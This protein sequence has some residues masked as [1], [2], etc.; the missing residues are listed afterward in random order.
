MSFQTNS[1][2]AL[3]AKLHLCLLFLLRSVGCTGKLLIELVD[4]SRRIDKLQFAC[5]KG[6]ANAANIYFEFRLGRPGRKFVPATTGYLRFHVFRMY[7]LFH[8]ILH[9]TILT[10]Y[11]KWDKIKGATSPA[12]VYFD[13][14]WTQSRSNSRPLSRWEVFSDAG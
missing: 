7:V 13:L 14:I 6:M 9:Q 10:F 5:V 8:D 12:R 4:A 1:G 2:Y 3:T 11:L